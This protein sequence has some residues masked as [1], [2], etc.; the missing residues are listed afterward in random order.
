MVNPYPTC[1]RRTSIRELCGDG[2][3]L[4]H[5]V[6]VKRVAAVGDHAGAGHALGART[7]NCRPFSTRQIEWLLLAL[8]ACW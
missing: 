5:S 4:G 7:L 8:A 3:T 6:E 1:G 2:E